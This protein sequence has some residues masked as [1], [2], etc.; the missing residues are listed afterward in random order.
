VGDIF[1]YFTGLGVEGDSCP[2]GTLLY[3]IEF[4][5][6]LSKPCTDTYESEKYL[7]YKS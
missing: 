1:L 6:P 2:Y 5:Y 4:L 7:K 3:S